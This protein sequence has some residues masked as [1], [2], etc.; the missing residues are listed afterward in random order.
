MSLKYNISIA[1]VAMAAVVLPTGCTAQDNGFNSLE[2]EYTPTYCFQLEAAYGNGMMSEGGVDGIEYMF[3]QITLSNKTA[4]DIGCGLGGVAFYLAQQYAMN[5]TGLEVN[6]WMVAEATN[7]T[8]NCL[9]GQVDFILSTS[10]QDWPLPS[11]M[12]DVI[13]SKGVLTHVAVKDPVF[14]ESHRLLKEKGLFVI[15]DWLSS[16]SKKWGENIQR[17]V[18]LENLVLFPESE[19]AYVQTLEKNGF[20]VISVR[21]DSSVYLNYNQKIIERLQHPQQFGGYTIYFTPEDA[22]ASIEGYE[23]IVKAIVAGELR[24]VRFI[25]Q[26]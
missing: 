16:D 3:D 7:R 8:P 12:F 23:S 2:E 26:K 1:V 19:S 5:I 17:L 14:Q 4:L 25:A 20:T 6:N 13:Y 9:K 10:N 21:D 18:D 24:V 11:N 22:A 15:T